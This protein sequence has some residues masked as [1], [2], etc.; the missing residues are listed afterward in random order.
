MNRTIAVLIIILLVAATGALVFFLAKEE[1]SGA[2]NMATYTGALEPRIGYVELQVSDLERSVA[3]YEDLIGFKVLKREGKTIQLSADGATPQ[4]VLTQEEPFVERPMRSTGLYHLAILVPSRK[5]LALSLMHLVGAGYPL[6]GAS[7]HQYSEALYLADPDNNGIEIYADRNSGQW[8]RDDN[9]GYV[10]ATIQLD[11]EGLLEEIKDA[12]WNG[13]SSETRIGHMHLQASDLEA[14]KKFYVEA[15]GFDVVAQDS[16]M[17]FV[18]KD[19]YHHHIGM[20]TWAGKGIPEPPENALGLNHFTFH[21]TREEF[22]EAKAG[23]AKANFQFVED[24]QTITVKDPSGNK[25]NL[26]LK[27]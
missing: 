3:F 8:I 14:S 2:M 17:L 7:D 5:Y 9:G 24:N 6:Q 13:L 18:S 27:N 23:L 19:A 26:I 1:N 11:I 4:L 21:L 10:G 12:E 25:L 20:N 16:Q 15:L 22:K